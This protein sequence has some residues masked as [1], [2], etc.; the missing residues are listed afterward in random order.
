MASKD[1]EGDI[2]RPPRL[3]EEWRF[4]AAGSKGDMRFEDVGVVDELLIGK[5]FHLEQMDSNLWCVKVG[6]A[7]LLVTVSKCQAV[8]DILRGAY[9]PIVGTTESSQFV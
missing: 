8:V 9:G 6:D 1:S 2:E 4:L 7:R 3:E 5:W